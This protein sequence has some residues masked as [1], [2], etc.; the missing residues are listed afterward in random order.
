MCSVVYTTA[1]QP[2]KRRHRILIHFECVLL[3]LNIV[4]C[5][6]GAVAVLLLVVKNVIYLMM[7][8]AWNA[9]DEQRKISG[10][11]EKNTNERKRKWNYED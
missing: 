11:S 1:S 5:E 2:A 3:L 9:K 10:L 7:I 8:K 6:V 4:S